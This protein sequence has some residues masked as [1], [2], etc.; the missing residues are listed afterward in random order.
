MEGK[1]VGTFD[2]KFGTDDMVFRPDTYAWLNASDFA[3]M[4]G[5]KSVLTSYV[6][7]LN[8]PAVQQLTTGVKG[9]VPDTPTYTP[10]KHSL[11]IWMGQL[12]SKHWAA[13]MCKTK[14]F[15]SAQVN[16]PAA[17]TLCEGSKGEGA[18]PRTSGDGG[19]G[20]GGCLTAVGGGDEEEA[21]MNTKTIYVPLIRVQQANQSTKSKRFAGTFA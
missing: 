15:M 19:S 2:E 8:T 18:E 13:F 4:T 1:V 5:Y 10:S 12:V 9:L 16:T 7:S 21:E 11:T 20:R 6:Y 3:T 17:P 14:T